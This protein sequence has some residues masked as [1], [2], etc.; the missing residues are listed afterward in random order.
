MIPEATIIQ[1]QYTG[2]E[3]MSRIPPDLAQ[4]ANWVLRDAD[5]VPHQPNGCNAKTNDSSTWS[6]LES[7]CEHVGQECYT[8]I[9]YVFDGTGIIG[10]DLDG[11]IVDGEIQPWAQ[12]IVDRFGSLTEYSPQRYG[13]AHLWSWGIATTR[14]KEGES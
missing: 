7:V 2:E 5:K 14:E 11:A 9:G 8:G 10:I 6:S 3:L 1:R 13:P 4:Q 12:E